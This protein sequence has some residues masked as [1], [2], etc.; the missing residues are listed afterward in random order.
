MSA[1]EEKWANKAA[2]CT[3]KA[4]EQTQLSQRAERGQHSWNGFTGGIQ[5][6]H[7]KVQNLLTPEVPPCSMQSQKGHQSE[8]R[9][10]WNTAEHASQRQQM[11][12]TIHIFVRNLVLILQV[13]GVAFQIFRQKF[14]YSVFI[15]YLLLSS[16]QDPWDNASFCCWHTWFICLT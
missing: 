3:L 11:C 6:L 12:K 7:K 5:S 16:S 8:N 2:D 10:M 15:H 13:G 1:L 14:L 9:A 4:E